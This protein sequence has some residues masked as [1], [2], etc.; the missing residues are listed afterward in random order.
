[1]RTYIRTLVTLDTI[2]WNPFWYVNSYFS[3]FIS[4]CSMVKSTIFSS[5]KSTYRKFVSFLSIHNFNDVFNEVRSILL[6]FIFIFCIFPS[7]WNVNFNYSINS[8]IYSIVVHF[9]NFF[10]FF[11]IRCLNC[12]FKVFNSFIYWNDFS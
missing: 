11:T 7:F 6:T 1:M 8:S 3:L 9:N 4:S 2:F 5:F 10:T 12:I